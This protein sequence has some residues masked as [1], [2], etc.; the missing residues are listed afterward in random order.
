MNILFYKGKPIRT[1]T[2]YIKWSESSVDTLTVFEH[3]TWKQFNEHESTLN[4]SNYTVVYGN[5]NGEQN[6]VG[7]FI[8]TKY[9]G[10]VS[11]VNGYA[12]IDGEII[13]E[14]IYE[15]SPINN[16]TN[17]TPIYG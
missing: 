7:L 8:G 11:S 12:H 9:S 5:C 3:T 14:C 4:S 13:E 16:L 6:V 1:I 15:I 17:I 2:F 10:I